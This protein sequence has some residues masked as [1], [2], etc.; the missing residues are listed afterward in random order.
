MGA[1]SRM[2]LRAPFMATEAGRER[3]RRLDA[4]DVP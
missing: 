2:S 1:L 4:P 3:R